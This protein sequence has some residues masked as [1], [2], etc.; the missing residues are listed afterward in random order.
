MAGG[1]VDEAATPSMSAAAGMG[2]HAVA[3]TAADFVTTVLLIGLVLNVV[4]ILGKRAFRR[5]FARPSTTSEG[6][7]KSD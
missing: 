5:I 3:L 6:A 1:V 7:K 2:D 4:R